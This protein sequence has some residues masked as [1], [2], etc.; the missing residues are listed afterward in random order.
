MLA[1]PPWAKVYERLKYGEFS[2]VLAEDAFVINDAPPPAADANALGLRAGGQA[3]SQAVSQVRLRLAQLR[4][5]SRGVPKIPAIGFEPD[6]GD[7]VEPPRRPPR[8]PPRP[9][10]PLVGVVV[11]VVAVTTGTC[12]VTC[13][14]EASTAP[15]ASKPPITMS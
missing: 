12:G 3:D 14:I 6:D 8:R 4:S 10:D 2:A 15:E 13:S 1:R 9:V 5:A 11:V 7:P